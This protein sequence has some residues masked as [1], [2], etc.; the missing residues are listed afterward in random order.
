MCLSLPLS[1]QAQTT[2]FFVTILAPGQHWTSFNSQEWLVIQNEPLHTQQS[3]CLLQLQQQDNKHNKKAGVHVY[4][5]KQKQLLYM[6]HWPD[7]NNHTLP[8][9]AFC[10]SGCFLLVIIGR[11]QRGGGYY[12][13]KL[14]I[15]LCV[16]VI[17]GWQ[18]MGW[19]EHPSIFL[20][21]QLLLHQLLKRFTAPHQY[22][23]VIGPLFNITSLLALL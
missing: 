7:F 16:C 2:Q 1:V 13:N 12:I 15:V 9:C 8:L 17:N 10:Q 20:C 3:H 5:V 4:L 22:Q 19:Q 18:L 21:C 14:W 6:Y 11:L 23:P